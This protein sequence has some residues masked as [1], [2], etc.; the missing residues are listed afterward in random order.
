MCELDFGVTG[1]L[2]VRFGEDETLDGDLEEQVREWASNVPAGGRIVVD[3]SQVR[4]LDDSGL[5]ILAALLERTPFG[6]HFRGLSDKH[7]KLL[8]YLG[9]DAGGL[10]EL[11]GG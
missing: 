8:G 1:D 9:W 6:A 11:A 3:L 5:A 7:M 10:G 4:T 2:L